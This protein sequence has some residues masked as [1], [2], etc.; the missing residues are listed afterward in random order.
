MM[1]ISA[2]YIVKDEAAELRRSLA[3]LRDA[4][5]EVVI[6]STATDVGVAELASNF[7]AQLWDFPWQNDFSA[8]R[9]YALGKVSG[10]FVI[11]LDADE[12]FSPETREHLRA[13][14][15]EADRTEGEVLL[16]PWHNIDEAT[17][18]T[19]LDS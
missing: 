9:N 3:S 14:I 4:V 1:R 17:R 2:C 13:V 6:V 16:I 10:E 12:Y 15:E 8:A 5:D 18:E 7:H 19:L 11:F